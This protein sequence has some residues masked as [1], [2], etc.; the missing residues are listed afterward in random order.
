MGLAVGDYDND[1]RVDFYITNFSDD[2]NTLYHNDGQ[3]DFSDVTFQAGH[4]E[5]TMPFLGWGTSFL[6]FDNDGWKDIFAVNGH[7]YPVV[8]KYQ[9]GTSYAQQPLLFRNL[10]SGRFDRVPAAPGSGLAVAI[11]ARGLAVGDLD[12][13]GLLD[14]VINNIDSAPT[15]LRNVTRPAG[16]WIEL[17]LVGDPSKKSPRDAIGAIAYVTTGKLRQRMD[18]VSGASYASQN[19]LKLHFGLG[20]ATRIDKLEVKWPDGALETVSIGGCDRVV[21]IIEGKGAQN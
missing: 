15:L 8:D 7:V 18:V 11:P 3:A 10:G 20:S 5:V 16:H 13:Y 2:S 9:W 19:D 14:A 21:T 12:G 4:G 1:G 6:D 17:R